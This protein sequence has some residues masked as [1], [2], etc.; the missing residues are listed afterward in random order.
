[1][2]DDQES[3][4]GEVLAKGIDG[5]FAHDDRPATVEMVADLYGNV[6]LLQDAVIALLAL[7]SKSAP[8]LAFTK[9]WH[10][11]SLAVRSNAKRVGDRLNE[12]SSSRESKNGK[13]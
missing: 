5:E 13:S 9:E 3:P 11:V 6:A 1:M 4:P 10:D 7:V 12:L 2:T 8:H